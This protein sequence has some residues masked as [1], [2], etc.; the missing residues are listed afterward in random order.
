MY[1]INISADHASAAITW[2]TKHAKDNYELEF[3]FVSSRYT[4]EFN[5]SE[6]A[7]MFALK[8]K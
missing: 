2:A 3:N 6:I 1:K 8:W 4:F 5:D 7:M